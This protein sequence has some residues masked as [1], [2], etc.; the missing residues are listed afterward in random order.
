M[1][2]DVDDVDRFGSDDLPFLRVDFQVPCQFSGLSNGII[3]HQPRL[4]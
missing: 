3:F 2:D 1:D 4:P